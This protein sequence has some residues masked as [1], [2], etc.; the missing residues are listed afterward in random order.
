MAGRLDARRQHSGKILSDDVL[1]REPIDP[2]SGAEA[3]PPGWARM[4]AVATWLAEAMK[5]HQAGHLAAAERIYNNILRLDPR[6]GDALQFLGLI[7]LSPRDAVGA[8]ERLRQALHINP[9]SGLYHFHLVPAPSQPGARA[10]A[11]QP[12]RTAI[13]HPPRHVE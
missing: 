11:G 5:Q 7:A 8:I 13:K 1:L 2:S 3:P 9:P 10:E 6:H 4:T 12:Y